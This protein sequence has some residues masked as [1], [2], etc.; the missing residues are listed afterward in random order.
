MVRA[1]SAWCLTANP[2]ARFL[3]VGS[4]ACAAGS[5]GCD[6]VSSRSGEIVSSLRILGV[7]SEPASALP[8]GTTELSVLCAD[9]QPNVAG[10]PAC[11]VEIAWFSGC[12]NP[13]QASP[14]RCLETYGSLA[15]ELATPVSATPADTFGAGLFGMGS[16][17]TFRAPSDVLKQ[18]ADLGGVPMRYGISYV[19]F[20]A[21]AGVLYP[22]SGVTDRLPVECRDPSS[23][24]R[25][26]QDRFVVGHTTIYSYEWLQNHNPVVAS[27]WFDGRQTTATPCA[28]DSQCPSE[29]V[30]RDASCIPRIQRCTTGARDCRRYHLFE[31]R[32]SPESF[33]LA[34]S[35]DVPAEARG[36]ALPP[37][38]LWVRYYAS[39]GDLANSEATLDPARY[40]GTSPPAAWAPP[41]DAADDVRLWAVVRDDRGGLAWIEQRVV[42]E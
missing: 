31:A 35:E 29:S 33:L 14:L 16:Q 30:C 9:G 7:R 32:V 25:L 15:S 42:V 26:G 10:R 27:A 12:Y 13:P 6:S 34:G 4:L 38:S 11:S 17:F 20:A 28:D 19:F 22:V 40:S 24:Q 1:S 8:G 36:L 18:Q 37:K 5:A 2:A 3:V 39:A 23:G 21:C 41:P